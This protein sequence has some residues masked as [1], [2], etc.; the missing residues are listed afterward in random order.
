MEIET[1]YFDVHVFFE[2]NNGYSLGVKIE[3]P[4][5][6]DVQEE[7]VIEFA[8]KNKLFT[9]E[10]DGRYVDIVDEIDEDEFN[11]IYSPL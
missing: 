9:D 4:V 6:T 10:G 11:S 8:E 5:D 7:D 1:K 3:V 2:R